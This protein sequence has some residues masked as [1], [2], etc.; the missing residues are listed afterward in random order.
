MYKQKILKKENTLNKISVTL[1]FILIGFL[2]IE[3]IFPSTIIGRAPPTPPPTFHEF[4]GQV[5][6]LSNQLIPDGHNVVAKLNNIDYNSQIINGNYSLTVSGGTS[7]QIIDFLVDNEN[8]TDEVFQNFGETSKNITVSD[9]FCIE[10][11]PVGSGG[12]SSGGGGGGGGSSRRTGCFDGKDND[13]DG[14]KDYPNDPGCSSRADENEIDPINPITRCADGEDND[15]DRKIDLNDPGC[16]NKFDSS[17]EDV[18][19]ETPQPPDISDTGI[20]PQNKFNELQDMISKGFVIL[21]LIIVLLLIY[22]FIKFKNNTN[23]N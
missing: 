14:K 19:I 2:L 13:N 22:F 16:V 12:G 8:V 5:K 18:V 23:P 6:C 20:E 3:S 17:E 9:S 7:G 11:T 21:V 1:L 15:N 4:E 10:T